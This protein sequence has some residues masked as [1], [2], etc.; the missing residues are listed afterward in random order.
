MEKEQLVVG[1]QEPYM[2]KTMNKLLH[3]ELI[4]LRRDR[5][6]FITIILLWIFTIYGL[7]TERVTALYGF[8]ALHQLTMLFAV[9]SGYRF[10]KIQEQK[11]IREWMQTLEYER[12][13]TLPQLLSLYALFTIIVLGMMCFILISYFVEPVQMNLLLE[14]LLVVF[15]HYLLPMMVTG[16]LGWAISKLFQGIIGYFLAGIIGFFL[17]SFGMQIYLPYVANNSILR[18]VSPLFGFDSTGIL[19][20]AL[21]GYD[22]TFSMWLRPLLWLSMAL[23]IAFAVRQKKGEK[24]KEK[25]IFLVSTGLLFVLAIAFASDENVLLERVSTISKEDNEYY[26]FQKEEVPFEA[27]LTYWD[28]LTLHVR[29]DGMQI[30]VQGIGDLVVQQDTDTI[31]LNLQ[32]QFSVISWKINNQEVDFLQE[33]DVI[34]LQHKG[35]SGENIQMDFTYEGRPHGHFLTD[36]GAVILTSN[37]HWFPIPKMG[38][39]MIFRDGSVTP[40]PQPTITT[41][42]KLFVEDDEPYWSNIQGEGEAQGLDLVFG[43]V[44]TQIID[45]VEYVYTDLDPVEIQRATKPV[46]DGIAELRKELG[47]EVQPTQRI[48]SFSELFTGSF[49]GYELDCRQSSDTIYRKW[50]T[51][52]YPPIEEQEGTRNQEFYRYEIMSSILASEP[53]FLYQNEEMQIAFLHGYAMIYAPY[54]AKYVP[55]PELVTFLEQV[56]NPM[57]FIKAW[58]DELLVEQNYT[59]EDL[60]NLMETYQ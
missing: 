55:Y 30:S 3:L 41:Y 42:Y 20:S 28:T 24:S 8:R 11:G 36:E 29:R 59:Y 47:L 14:T 12:R 60:Q 25:T 45:E 22:I 37:Y 46:L 19:Y 4:R 6:N 53:E 34:T 18:S 58:H 56:E 33:D 26:Y 54:S 10:A 51:F 50:G 5:I 52:L 23:F 44:S 43:R 32:R 9:F 31:Q 21:S 49:G 27:P 1:A 39:S 40:I 57:E 16:T 48:V 15:L 38:Q 7:W 13:R 2:I 17:G 35:L